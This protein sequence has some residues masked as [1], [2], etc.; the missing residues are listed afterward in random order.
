MK[1]F[2][3]FLLV[4]M[5]FALVAA[6]YVIQTRTKSAGKEV[7]RLEQALEN[8]QA[9]IAVLN[10]E[11]AHLESP[12][13]LSGLAKAHLDLQPA[14]PEQIVTLDDVILRVPLRKPDA[15]AVTDRAAQ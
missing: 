12:K 14:S 5:G 2:G 8:E 7:R 1:R 15:Q 6:L 11:I 9:A 13:R 4:L 3:M 10:A